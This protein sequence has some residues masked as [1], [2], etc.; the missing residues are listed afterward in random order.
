MTC[1]FILNMEIDHI[2]I[3]AIIIIL[4]IYLRFNELETLGFSGFAF[5]F[6]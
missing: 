2:L 6:F 3:I 5:F 1:N 4:C